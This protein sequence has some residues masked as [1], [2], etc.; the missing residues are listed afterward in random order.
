VFALGGALF[1]VDP[2]EIPRLDAVDLP[3]ETVR[4]LGWTLLGLTLVYFIIVGVWRKPIKVQG[5]EVRLPGLRMSMLQVTV[6]AIDFAVAAMCLY[7]L[8]PGDMVVS[9]TRFLAIFMLAWVAVVITHVPGGVAVFDV[10][11]IALTHDS[12]KDEVLVALA[13]Y[14]VLYYLLPTLI[15]M[16]MFFLHEATIRGSATNRLVVRLF[17]DSTTSGPVPIPPVEPV[18]VKNDGGALKSADSP[19]ANSPPPG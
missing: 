2:F 1:I 12:R 10:V 9:Y 6:A 7:V 4:P 11:I 14:R 19:P 15:A 17:G 8:L 18:A 13:T 3:F 16:P 5:E